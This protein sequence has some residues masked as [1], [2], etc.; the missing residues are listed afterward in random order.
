MKFAGQDIALDRTMPRMTDGEAS[1]RFLEL[2]VQ[3]HDGE[4]YGEGVFGGLAETCVDEARRY[5]WRVCEALERET[6]RLARGRGARPERSRAPERKQGESS[7]A[8]A[9][10]AAAG[11]V[12]QAQR[13][14]IAFRG[15]ETEMTAVRIVPF[16]RSLAQVSLWSPGESRY[17]MSRRR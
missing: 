13:A 2:L 15:G 8:P 1:Q 9:A 7:A 17:R 5:K 11:G 14:T 4:V 12:R 3:R 10:D 16:A 6:Q